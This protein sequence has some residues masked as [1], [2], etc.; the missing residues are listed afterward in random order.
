MKLFQLC[1][2]F[3]PLFR[4]KSERFIQVMPC[5][6][7]PSPTPPHAFLNPFPCILPPVPSSLFTIHSS[8]FTLHYSLFTIHSSLFILP[9]SPPQRL[10]PSRLRRDASLNEGGRPPLRGGCQRFALTGGVFDPVPPHPLPPPTSLVSKGNW[11]T[12]VGGGFLFSILSFSKG[13]RPFETPSQRARAKHDLGG[14]G[15]EPPEKLFLE[16]NFPLPY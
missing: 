5:P 16:K 15:A 11:L 12:V 14:E 2:L 6:L 1:N 9:Y 13:L 8:L 3:G 4:Q 7:T 10:P